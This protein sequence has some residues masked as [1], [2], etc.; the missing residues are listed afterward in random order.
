MV[1]QRHRSNVISF[2]YSRCV[3]LG[4]VRILI[5]RVLFSRYYY[6]VLSYFVV[7][8]MQRHSAYS[9]T[10]SPSVPPAECIQRTGVWLP[11]MYIGGIVEARTNNNYTGMTIHKQLTDVSFPVCLSSYLAENWYNQFIGRIFIT[12]LNRAW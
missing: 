2:S 4:V 9:A 8:F 7:D 12:I 10:F 1:Q 11:S 5:H 3:P 6:Y